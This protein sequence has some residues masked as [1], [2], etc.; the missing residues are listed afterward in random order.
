MK[1]TKDVKIL[2]CRYC[3]GQ[4]KLEH[5]DFWKREMAFCTICGT[6]GRPSVWDNP[7]PTP[8]EQ[9]LEAQNK[10]LWDLVGECEKALLTIRRYAG[11]KRCSFS[12]SEVIMRQEIVAHCRQGITAIQ[13]A[14]EAR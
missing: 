7:Y 8:R 3:G 6:N 5:N 2:P 12:Q 14:K 13:K 11:M 10:A 4:A 1:K 9:E